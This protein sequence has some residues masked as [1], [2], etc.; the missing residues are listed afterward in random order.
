MLAI[1]YRP[2]ESLKAYENNVKAHPKE[3]IEGIKYSIE[4]FGMCDPIAVDKDGTIIEGHGRLEALKQLGVKQVPVIVLADLTHE[5]AKV[6]RLAHN[7]LA[8]STGVDVKQ[9]IEELDSV[10]IELDFEKLELPKD[11]E[12]EMSLFEAIEHPERQAK[13]KEI[14]C[15]L[16]G[17]KF[18]K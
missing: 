18:L 7:S 5:Q 2:I 13:K 11:I 3:Q 16:C 9:L 12:V 1:E 14:E 4:Q 8:L 17:G 10:P 15:P 6:Y